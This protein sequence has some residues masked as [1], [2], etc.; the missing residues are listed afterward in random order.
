MMS[1]GVQGEVDENVWEIG[2]WLFSMAIRSFETML[3]L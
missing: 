2:N 3:L 1:K